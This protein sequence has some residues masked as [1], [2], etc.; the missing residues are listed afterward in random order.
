MAENETAK[1]VP[2]ENGSQ[3]MTSRIYSQIRA[4]IISG[5]LEPAKKMK[6]EE[7]RRRYDAGASPIREA[8]SLLTSDNLIERMDQ[9][10]FRVVEVSVEAFEELLKTRIW[11]EEIALRQSVEN[12]GPDWE[13]QIL[14]AAHRLSRVPRSEANDP[15]IANAE[16]EDKH[17]HLH[18]SFLAAC[19][20]SILLNFCNQ[21]YDQNTRYRHLS[22]P[23]AYPARHINVEHGDI[24]DAL[25]ARDA[26]M[27][28]KRL[29]EH[30]HR[31]SGFLKKVI[32]ARFTT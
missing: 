30:Y 32:Q 9:R 28:V 12:G 14:L 3:S 8:L 11:V 29:T 4:D 5:T 19:G 16:W 25:L 2:G 27:A 7:L 22:A 23:S 31:T 26:N 13:E 18:M 21:L 10:G 6:I 24:C 17:K 1:A 20:S 15:F